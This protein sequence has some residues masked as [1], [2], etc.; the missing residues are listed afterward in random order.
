MLKKLW[1]VKKKRCSSHI[2]NSQKPNL[3]K[4]ARLRSEGNE[5]G[6]NACSAKM[7]LNKAKRSDRMKSTFEK[8]VAIVAKDSQRKKDWDKEY[9][10]FVAFKLFRATENGNNDQDVIDFLEGKNKS[11]VIKAALRE[12]IEN[13]KSQGG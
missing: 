10:V 3:Y 13:H 8:V 5:Q 4:P 1:E 11:A 9:M 2:I 7:E 6:D 12:Y